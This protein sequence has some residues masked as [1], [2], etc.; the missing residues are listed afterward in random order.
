VGIIHRDLK[1]ENVMIVAHE[2]DP[3]F[4]KVLD[5]GIAKF[6]ALSPAQT[7]PSSASG[8]APLTKI[9][10]IFGT[11][12][13]MSP[14]QSLGQAVDLRTDLYS[15]GVIF[16]ELLTGERLFK[17]GAVTL[18][19][20]HVLEQAPPLPPEVTKEVGSRVAAIVQKLL[21]KSPNDRFA[22]S[23]ELIAALDSADL[24]VEPS[25]EHVT[26]AAFPL[27]QPPTPEREEAPPPAAGR[28]SSEDSL[29]PD[30]SNTRSAPSMAEPRKKKGYSFGL[31]LLALMVA[32][33]AWVYFFGPPDALVALL[34]QVFV[35]AS[36]RSVASSVP[37]AL[38][39]S[40]A[41]AASSGASTPPIPVNTPPAARSD[42]PVATLSSG[43]QETADSAASAASS[44]EERPAASPSSAEAALGVD[45][46]DASST[47]SDA[48]PPQPHP[49]ASHLLPTSKPPAKP[50]H[51][52]TKPTP[53]PKHPAQPTN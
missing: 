42:M 17:G 13:Y 26:T 52:P 3:N 40:F 25:S 47:L 51:K 16:H 5:F 24:E 23:A 31:P 34:N 37:S 30:A 39:V 33:G 14:E 28:V 38:P 22:S 2:G 12:D 29:S 50:I 4:V 36:A 10:A 18:M 43:G 20:S 48:A 49:S 9:G 53:P 32:A 19:R 21:Q 8:Q 35:S 27:V 45:N 44:I 46:T 41:P 7:A 15:I 11:P 6:D 1:P